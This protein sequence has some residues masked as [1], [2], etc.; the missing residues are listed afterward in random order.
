MKSRWCCGWVAGL[1]RCST[2]GEQIKLSP[3][4][5]WHFHFPID[6]VIQQ[7]VPVKEEGEVLV[8]ELW[9]PLADSEART[10]R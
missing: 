5:C 10:A 9:K 4:C 1:A 2:P 7:S 3:A 8:D 6:R